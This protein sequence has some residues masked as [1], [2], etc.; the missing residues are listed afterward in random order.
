MHKTIL[1]FLLT[2]VAT[3]TRA[4]TIT[5]HFTEPYLTVEHDTAAATLVFSG[6][7]IETEVYENIGLTI[8]GVNSLT[9]AWDDENRLDLIINYQGTDSMSDHIYPIEAYYGVGANE[10]RLRQGGCTT[11][12]LPMIIPVDSEE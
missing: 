2:A 10:G 4:D 3:T 6:L 8:T 7:G 11:T 12:R 1:L 9:L 5:C